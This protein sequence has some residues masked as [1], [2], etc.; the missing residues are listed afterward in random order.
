M[1]GDG[2]DGWLHAMS[3]QGL[4]EPR[5]HRLGLPHTFWPKAPARSAAF[6]QGGFY[7]IRCG[8]DHLVVRCGPVGIRGAGSHD[9]NDQLGFELVVDGRRIVTDSGTY[10]YTRDL[11]ARY[12]FRSTAAHSVIQ[13]GH[14]E[15]NP[16]V[17]EMPWPNGAENSL[18]AKARAI[19]WWPPLPAN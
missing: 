3:A 16:I 18:P 4:S 2:D 8:R 11:A 7:V 15:Q 14:E 1:L 9:H 10:T 13:L 6:P 17:P 19:W 12:A 5:R